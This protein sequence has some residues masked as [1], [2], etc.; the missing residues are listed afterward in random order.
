M[1]DR[2]SL[3]NWKGGNFYPS[4]VLQLV[5]HVS[6]NLH[7]D[8]CTPWSDKRELGRDG[9]LPVSPGG[10]S[11]HSFGHTFLV[12]GSM[13]PLNQAWPFVFWP[14]MHEIRW[15][16]KM[17]RKGYKNMEKQPSLTIVI[18]L[19]HRGAALLSPKCLFVRLRVF[20]A[21]GVPVLLCGRSAFVGGGIKHSF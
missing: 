10:A 13:L 16:K 18:V 17:W 6:C 11:K 14:L 5:S 3:V 1:W 9:N 15:Q 8:S 4:L 7:V 21:T 2:T 12:V 20:L 19:D